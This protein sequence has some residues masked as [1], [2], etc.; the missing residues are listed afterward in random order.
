MQ[1]FLLLGVVVYV[2]CGVRHRRGLGPALLWPWCR[3]AA[4]DPVVPL[5]WE[6]PVIYLLKSLQSLCMW[7][8]SSCINE[9]SVTQRSLPED[10][11]P[12]ERLEPGFTCMSLVSESIG[13][14]SPVFIPWRSVPSCDFN[15]H[16]CCRHLNC[17]WPK[18][19]YRFPPTKPLL[20]PSFLTSVS[21]ITTWPVSQLNIFFLSFFF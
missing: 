4:I 6:P 20:P 3:L 21:G 18:Q 7:W 10:L 9:R 15:P 8:F 2:S 14:L 11:P 16:P 17:N 1:Y 12:L 19:N 13:L 5:A